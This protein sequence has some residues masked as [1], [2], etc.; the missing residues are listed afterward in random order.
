MRHQNAR[1]FLFPLLYNRHLLQEYGIRIRVFTNMDPALS[2]CDALLIDSKAV[3]DWWEKDTDGVL[4][5][6]ER[7]LQGC[8]VGYFDLTDSASWLRAEVIPHVTL[9]YKNQLLA[10]RDL[11]MQ[12]LYG[13][14]LFTD[15][16]HHTAGV[17]DDKPERSVSLTAAQIAKLRIS[18]N[19]GLSNYALYGPRVALLS[20][21]LHLPGL[22]FYPRRF[23]PPRAPRPVALSC[24]MNVAYARA[25]VA[26][27]RLRARELL[28]HYARSDRLSK[29][30]YFRELR[31]SRLVASPFGWGEI[32][33]K[34]Y[35]CFLSGAAIVKP[36]MSHL[37][38]WPD[39][40][41]AGET[42]IAHSWDMSDLLPQVER[43]L[44]DDDARI[45]VAQAGQERYRWH[46]GTAAGRQ[47][48][49]ERFAGR[50]AELQTV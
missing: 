11:L 39:W 16:Y 44:A 6:L 9:Y 7:W 32:N 27:Q 42:Y 5:S 20:E 41:V 35:E 36:D 29:A 21:R 49:C 10:E 34:D 1:G 25:T 4:A 8:P 2:D 46:I 17:I 14:R 19:A 50:L 23:H 28:Q 30:G 45:A 24:R 18:W 15:Y 48:F 43:Y 40:F 38:T 13:R 47:A 12:P 37:E 33:Q 3:D 26:Y 31:E 22:L